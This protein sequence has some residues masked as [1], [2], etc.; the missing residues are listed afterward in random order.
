MSIRRCIGGLLALLLVLAVIPAQGL[1]RASSNSVWVAETEGAILLASSDGSIQVEISGFGNV[2]AAS[3]DVRRETVWLLGD[4]ELAAFDLSGALRFSV[5]MSAPGSVHADM[6][7]VPSTGAVWVG[8]HQDLLNVGPEGQ[9]LGSFGLPAPTV[10]LG[11]DEARSLVWVGTRES[12][13]ARDLVSGAVVGAL[14]LPA[15]ERLRD[16]SVEPASGRVWVASGERVHLHETS[17]EVVLQAT[18]RG[19][20]RVAAALDG[21]AWIT[22]AKEAVRLGTDGSLGPPS[23]PLDGQGTLEHLIVSG[24]GTAWVAN[25]TTVARIAADGATLDRFSFQPPIRVWDLATNTDGTAPVLEIEAPSAD[26]CLSDAKPPIELSYSDAGWGVD[27]G[28]LQLFVDGQPVAASCMSAPESATCRLDD[29]LAEGGRLLGVTVSDYAGNESSRAERRVIIDTT[30][31]QI[32]VSEPPDGAI[33]EEPEVTVSGTLNEPAELTIAGSTV[34]LEDDLSFS[35]GPILLEEGP[36]EIELVAADCA[37][38]TGRVTWMVVYEPSTGGLPPDPATVAPALDPTVPTDFHEGTR[39]LYEGPTPIQLDVD[40]GTID[41]VRVAVVRGRVLSRDGEPLPGVRVEVFGHEELGHTLSRQDGAFDLAVNGGAELTLAYSRAGYLPAHRPV[42]TPWRD[43]VVAEDVVLLPHDDNAT[44]VAMGAADAQVARGSVS[45]DEDGTR[46]A[47]LLV[48]AGTQAELVLPDGSRQP[49]PSLTMRATEYTVGPRGPQAMPAPLPPTSGYTYAVEL[50]ADEAL[51]AGATMIAFDAPVYLYVENFLDFAV[52]SIVPAGYYDRV[53]GVWVPSENGQVVEILDAVGGRAVLDVNGAGQPAAASELDSLGVTDSELMR[54][55]ELYDPGTSLWRTPIPHFT[56][57]DC[58]WPYGPPEDAEEPPEP[59]A[60]EPD[61]DDPE[62]EEE[63]NDDEPAEDE[64]DPAC[65]QG[66]VIECEN[67]VF[68]ETID[69]VGASQALHYRSNRVPGRRVADLMKVRLSGPSVPASLKRIE[70]RIGIAGRQIRRTFAPTPNQT[71]TFTWDRRD[72]YGRILQG[73]HPAAAHVGYVYDAVYYEPAELSAA[74][75]AVSSRSQVT[76]N[77]SAAEVVLWRGAWKRLG[78]SDAAMVGLG[79]WTLSDHHVYDPS[80]REVYLGNGRKRRGDQ[81]ESFETFFGTAAIPPARGPVSFAAVPDGSLFLMDALPQG[82]SAP[83]YRVWRIRPDGLRETPAAFAVQTNFTPHVT[84]AP[85]GDPYVTW[86]SGVFPFLFSE[87]RNLATGRVWTS[88]GP[89][90]PQE[91]VAAP[92]GSFYYLDIARFR[93]IHQRTDGTASTLWTGSGAQS[94]VSPVLD[95]QG[96]IYVSAPPA[97]QVLRIDPDGSTRVVVGTGERGFG[98]DGGLASEARLDSPRS[99]AIAPDESLLIADTRNRRVR[100]V[101]ASGSIHTLIGSGSGVRTPGPVPPLAV[102]LSFLGDLAASVDGTIYVGDAGFGNQPLQELTRSFPGFGVGG[103][104]R[105]A[106]ETGAEVFTF[107]SRGRHLR[108]LNALTGAT[109][110]VFGYDA[111]GWLV[112]ITDA[113]GNVTRIERDASGTPTAI[114]APFGQRTE[115]GLDAEG[116]LASVT[117]PAGESHRFEYR[118]GG[119]LRS[120]TDPE[121][122]EETAEYSPLGRLVAVR[123]AAGGAKILQ[124]WVRGPGRYRVTLTTAEGRET[125][126]SFGRDVGG[127]EERAVSTEGGTTAGTMVTLDGSSRLALPSGTEVETVEGADPRFGL[128]APVPERNSVTTPA[129]LRRESS[130]RHDATLASEADPFSVSSLSTTWTVNGRVGSRSFDNMTRELTTVSPEGR[131]SVTRVDEHFRPVEVHLPDVEPRIYQYDTR[132]RL[133]SVSQGVGD[134]LRRHT[135]S[136]GDSGRLSAVRD[137]LEREVRFEYDEA[138][139][140]RQQVQPD[141]RATTFTYDRNGNLTSVR[142]PGK[143]PHIFDYTPRDLVGAYEPPQLD[144]SDTATRYLFDRDQRLFQITRP[145]GTG[146]SIAYDAAGRPSTL[147]DPIGT[148]VL[149]YATTGHLSSLRSSSNEVAYSYD[150]PLLTETRWSGEIRGT[151]GRTY[152]QNFWVRSRSVNGAAISF[153]YDD[154]DL[155]TRAGELIVARDPADG[156]VLGT[157]AGSVETTVTYDRFGD[158]SSLEASSAADADLY[159]VTFGRDAV[160]RIVTKT[161]MVSGLTNTYD[162]SYDTAGRLE[163]VERNGA[164]VEEYEYD[165]NGNRLLATYP[166]GQRPATYDEQDRLLSHGDATFSFDAAG[167]LVSRTAGAGSVTY[168]YDVFGN[169]RSVELESGDVIGYVIDGRQRRIGRTLNGSLDRGW[170]YKDQLN[171]VAELDADGDVVSRF[172]YGFKRNVPAYMVRGGKSYRFVSDHLGSMRLVVEIESATIAQRMDYD[173]FGRVVLDTNPGFQ[174]F[175]FAGG[176]YDSLTGFTRFGARDYDAQTGRWTTRDPL[177]FDGGLANLYGYLG[178]D[179]VNQIDV[180]GLEVEICSEVADIPGNVF[181]LKHKWIRTD[182]KEAGLGQAGGGVPGEGEYRIRDNSPYITETEVVDHDDRGDEEGATCEPVGPDIDEECVNRE[183][184]IGE[185]RG[186]WSGFNQCQ[187]Y[188]SEIIRTCR[189]PPVIDFNPGRP[190][191]RQSPL[192]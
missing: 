182:E 189:K 134:D 164:E 148:L 152:D 124:R 65:E 51:A 103:E 163:R 39:F 85:D 130:L 121:G 20:T 136:Y 98:G 107:D 45:V 88:F 49:I 132:G 100:R 58:N 18:F 143:P 92:D 135:V 168:D 177:L 114:V 176:L 34:A 1:D 38:N 74:F 96:R 170:L 64:E 99:L 46:Q 29:P 2:R 140:V 69:L 11:V 23:R 173:S 169:L 76:T 40:P 84:V 166:W 73:R 119:L 70:L 102:G 115:L 54:L 156:K 77:R 19:V 35:Y 59:D 86:C 120:I 118:A 66:S 13:E 63:Q 192:S 53:A 128:Q 141:G 78:A 123:D 33:L 159:A 43:F 36:N 93:L 171:P 129:G 37:G 117:N 109:K 75:A 125:S 87:I 61:P 162:Y 62:M 186:R 3:V 28:T 174:P 126:Y 9:V 184:V 97:H 112:S 72:A 191:Y 106:S 190:G 94:L 52:G 175:G 144:L 10:S 172:V 181:G 153:E 91:L 165:D 48:P 178:S 15:G 44:P 113:F 183:I 142:P 82:F 68:G 90:C 57:W 21:G 151:I 17:G 150:G 30:A 116:Y 155:L 104:M 139:R 160:G 60:E 27:P 31:P 7:V 147:V 22:G 47:T 12:V 16:L 67:Q 56:P 89:E 187:T 158:L 108:T 42:R 5:D 122:H 179:P 180:D 14:P 167:D 26:A 80:T 127:A 41:P 71:F 149:D 146:V 161:E 25:Q 157:V 105:I 83:I 8:A 55:A 138:G 81:P 188:V 79:G 6:A 137:P 111:G 4:G 32:Q 95:A 133:I 185:R 131:S 110:R 24:D 154:D 50:A 101:A 145:D